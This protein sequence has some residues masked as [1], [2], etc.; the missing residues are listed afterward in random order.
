MHTV[1]EAQA[2]GEAGHEQGRLVA[3]HLNQYVNSHQAIDRE[4]YLTVLRR[5]ASQQVIQLHTA[6]T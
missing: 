6:T 5:L 4:A 1:Q 3:L 2:V